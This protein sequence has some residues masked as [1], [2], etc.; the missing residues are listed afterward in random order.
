MGGGG[1][2]SAARAL[3][4]ACQSGDP[5]GWRRILDILPGLADRSIAAF[6][7]PRN[8]ARAKQERDQKGR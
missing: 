5:A 3:E 1:G 8:E 7:Q 2:H 6:P 4:A